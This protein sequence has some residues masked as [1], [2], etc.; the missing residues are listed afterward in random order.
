ML[1]KD[2]PEDERPRE[3]IAAHG[4][5]SLSDAEILALFFGTGRQG[6]SAV[7][8]G[9]DMISR[10][11]SLRNLSRA[12]V[13]ELLQINGIGPAKAAQLAAVFEFGRRLSR[14][15]FTDTPVTCPEEVY[16]L[17]GSSMQCLSQ[18]SVRVILL[19]HRKKLIHIDEVFRGTGNESFANPPEILR[20]AISHA[21]HSMIL[22][23]NHPSGDPSPSRADHEVTKRM[24]DACR[25][26]GI[27]F[28]DH[29]VIG[30]ESG[31]HERAPY[32]SFRE[33]GLL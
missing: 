23:H 10:F 19:N 14:E 7:E 6:V 17:V 1:I 20:R 33:A 29:V 18:E 25:A 4:A 32:F 13:A 5:E 22:V 21:A 28:T 31:V 8:L 3:R 30:G 15:A 26:V 16:A 24:A 9:R 2:L 27:E 11:G 12:T